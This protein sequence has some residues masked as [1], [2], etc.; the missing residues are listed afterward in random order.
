MNLVIRKVFSVKPM[1]HFEENKICSWL[2]FFKAY[3]PK[4]FTGDEFIKSLIFTGSGKAAINIIFEYLKAIGVLKDKNSEI[5]VA[6]WLGY[7]VY[8]IIH[9]V[10]F[11]C[12]TYNEK[13][14]VIFVYHQYGFPQNMDEIMDFAQ[15]KKLIIIEDCAHVYESYYKGKRLGTFGLA[16]IFSLSKMFP[17]F[18]GG[19]ILTKDNNLSEFVFEKLKENDSFASIF[20]LLAKVLAAK[21]SERFVK[22]VGMSYTVYDRNTRMNRVSMNLM[23][24]ELAKGAIEK[25]RKNYFFLL[26]NFKNYT[27]FQNLERDALPYVVPL[28]TEED[29]LQRINNGLNSAGFKTGLYHFDV[30]RNLLNPDFKKSVW[31]PIHQGLTINDMDRIRKIIQEALN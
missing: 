1:R 9:K 30:N 22:Y 11:P 13:V 19:A 20:S 3:W 16:S 17:T 7:W 6:R 25:R 2:E 12:L 31:V 26:D 27:F 18:M 5:L 21:I 4:K 29:K 10:A 23:F 28:I 8:N 14:K 24:N 15:R